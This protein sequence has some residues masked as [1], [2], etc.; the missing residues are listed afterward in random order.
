V[1]GASIPVSL[2]SVLS[3]ATSKQDASQLPR[4]AVLIAARP[5]A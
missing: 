1:A 4:A 3:R 2:V 5:P